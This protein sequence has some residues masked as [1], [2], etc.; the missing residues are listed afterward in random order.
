VFNTLFSFIFNG[1]FLDLWLVKTRG[2]TL[3]YLWRTENKWAL[4]ESGIHLSSSLVTSPSRRTKILFY[5]FLSL[6][7]SSWQVCIW[8]ILL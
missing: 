2:M 5:S 3:S 8:E 4:G 7:V 6:M 1:F